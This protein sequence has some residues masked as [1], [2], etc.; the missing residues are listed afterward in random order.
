VTDDQSRLGGGGHSS[1]FAGDPGTPAAAL[2]RECLA[3]GVAAARP[4]RAVADR[5]TVEDGR[6]HLTGRHRAATVSLA[7]HDRLLLVG[8]GKAARGLTEALVDTLAAA[9]ATPDGGT[10][11]VPPEDTGRRQR[12]GFVAGGHPTPTPGG[13]AATRDAVATLDDAGEETLV[14]APVTGGGSALLAAPVPAVGLSALQSV[15]RRLLDAGAS[16]DEL[17]AVRRALSTVKGGRLAARAAPARVVGVVLSDVVGDDPAVVASGPTAPPPD[18]GDPLAVLRRYDVDTPRV[19]GFLRAHDREPPATDTA[20]TVVIASGARALAAARD[21][22]RARG[23]DAQV[24]AR[25]VTGEARRCGRRAGALAAT[26]T[27]CA[28]PT[29][30]RPIVLLAGGE[31]TVSVTGDGV[32]GPNCE[33]VTGAAL[34]LARRGADAST[35][36]AAIDTDG[37]DGST[38][39]AGGLVSGATAAEPER[40]RR[41]LADNDSLAWLEDIDAALHSGATGTNVDDLRVLVVAP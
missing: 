22:A 11:L 8:G 28:D 24:L 23:A 20:E 39:A 32:G 37:H 13:V 19:E 15:T 16:V 41:A 30:E 36:V 21:H 31:T 5:V 38:D 3:A 4:A 7:D 18:S 27:D 17:N 12:V 9:N 25:G 33:Y 26:V 1:L 2:A 14:L 34:E 40:A 35:V 10:V 6:L 29:R